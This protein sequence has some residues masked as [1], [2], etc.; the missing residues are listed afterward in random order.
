MVGSM[1]VIPKDQYDTWFKSQ[2]ESA[3]KTNTPKPPAVA[4]INP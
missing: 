4:M 1:E 2:T 3:L